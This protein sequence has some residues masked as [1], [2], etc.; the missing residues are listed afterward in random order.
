VQAHIYSYA[1]LTTWAWLT[2]IHSI[3]PSPIFFIALHICFDIT[4]P[5]VA[6]LSHCCVDI[7][8]MIWVSIYYIARVGVNA[9]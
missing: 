6:H 3:Y 4:H 7:P 9:L 1:S 2:P 5:I 8:L